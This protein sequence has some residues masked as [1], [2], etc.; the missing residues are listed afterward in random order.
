MKKFLKWIFKDEYKQF[1]QNIE[2]READRAFWYADSIARD[3]RSELILNK[4]HELGYR[5]QYNFPMAKEYNIH[6]APDLFYLDPKR[7]WE[8]VPIEKE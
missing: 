8:I 5:L 6:D 4:L 7:I 1:I 3:R 2:W